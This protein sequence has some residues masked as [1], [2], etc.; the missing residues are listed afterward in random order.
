[1]PLRFNM[2][3]TDAGLDPAHVRLLRHQTRGAGGK[4][5]YSLWRDNRTAFDQF[6]SMQAAEYRSRFKAPYWASFVVPPQ[7]GTLFVGLYTAT[8]AGSVLPG[9]V[10][11]LTDERITGSDQALL[12]DQ[13]SCELTEK[14]AE[15]IGRIHIKW[16]DS[17]SAARA[18][19]QRADKQDKEITELTLTLREDP[20][21]GF[22]KFMRPLSEIETMPSAWKQVLKTA[23]GIYLLTCPNTGKHYVG[24]AYGAGGFLSR[25]QDYVR[26]NHGGNIKLRTREWSD[27]CVSILEVAG[28]SATDEEIIALEHL[29]MRKLLTR[30]N[31]FNS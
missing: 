31:G 13:Y 30:N 12:P 17:A 8:R 22:S 1:M 11:L 5:P 18:W 24:S 4:T 6:Q 23:R 28:S 15:Y 26:N 14:L 3:L 16:G 10:D 25:W 7:G 19:V 2:L 27:Y 21:P 9:T 29:W 20:F